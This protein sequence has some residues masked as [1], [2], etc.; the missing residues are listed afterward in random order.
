LSRIVLSA[1]PEQQHLK[2]EH[3]AAPRHVC[4]GRPRVS[5]LNVNETNEG[6]GRMA[7][8]IKSP[9]DLLVRMLGEMLYVEQ[10]QTEEVLPK[11][12]KE[13]HSDELRRGLEQHLEQTRQQR[14]RVEQAF[15][16]IGERPT[17]QTNH[18]FSGVRAAHD[19]LAENIEGR[20]LRDVFD[21]DAAAKAEH[22]EV[23]GYHALVTLAEQ[24]GEAELADALREVER[25]EERMIGQ[26]E[27]VQ[28]DLTRQLAAA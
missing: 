17:P 8:S 22:L 14:S 3:G 24:L 1:L 15:E 19:Q 23:A 10:Q 20:E 5:H 16:L 13:V 12:I 7:K 26:L 27:R 18:A 25:Q 6:A 4:G 2:T 11:L 9:H 28:A 21:A